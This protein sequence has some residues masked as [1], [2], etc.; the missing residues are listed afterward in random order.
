MCHKRLSVGC[1][2]E[3]RQKFIWNFPPWNSLKMS[4][5]EWRHLLTL[6]ISLFFLCSV[7]PEFYSISHFMGWVGSE[8]VYHLSFKSNWSV[9]E[10]TQ[11]PKLLSYIGSETRIPF[12]EKILI[13]L[14]VKGWSLNIKLHTNEKIFLNLKDKYFCRNEARISL[15]TGRPAF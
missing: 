8:L 1:R 7:D 9:L 14:T 10:L 13:I 6:F 5:S 2:G 3:N 11:Q 12:L 4:G 15:Y